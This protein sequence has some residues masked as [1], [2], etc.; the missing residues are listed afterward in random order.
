MRRLCASA[1]C[2]SCSATMART[3]W[4]SCSSASRWP[5]TP[6]NSASPRTPAP[7]TSSSAG[8]GGA[9]QLPPIS[10]SAVLGS[11]ATP[12]RR[13]ARW[14][15]SR[16]IVSTAVSLNSRSMRWARRSRRSSNSGHEPGTNSIQRPSPCSF[17]LAA[18]SERALLRYHSRGIVSCACAI[19][20]RNT[21]SARIC[22]SVRTDSSFQVRSCTAATISPANHASSSE[23]AA[24]RSGHRTVRRR[25]N[26]SQCGRVTARLQ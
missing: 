11:W 21:A 24:Y 25:C 3:A 18:S 4:S 1:V 23:A 22:T 17:S 7:A 8:T 9:A 16:R 15:S 20:A 14:N 6:A 26:E 10:S 2:G 5:C 19:R 13:L 12:V